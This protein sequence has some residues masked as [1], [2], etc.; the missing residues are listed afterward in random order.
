MLN[1][2]IDTDMNEMRNPYSPSIVLVGNIP[3]RDVLAK[4]TPDE[5]RASVRSQLNVMKD[6]SSII[7]SCR[8]EMLPGVS[9]D[10]L[11]AFIDEVKTFS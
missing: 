1:F 6:T 8:G 7:M 9:N 3:P 5:V 11:N 4:G 2:G 10:N